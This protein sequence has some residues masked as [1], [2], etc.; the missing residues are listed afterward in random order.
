VR[1]KRLFWLTQ[2]EPWAKLSCPFGAEPSGRITDAKQIP[3]IDREGLRA[4]PVARLGR[5]LALPGLSPYLGLAL[6]ALGTTNA[7]PCE[8]LRLRGCKQTGL[9]E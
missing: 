4:A 3:T 6:P 8:T 7:L 5:S 9:P 2:G 1:A